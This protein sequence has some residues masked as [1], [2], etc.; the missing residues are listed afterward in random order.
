M[1]SPRQ[2][3]GQAD[4]TLS[5]RLADSRRVTDKLFGLVRPDALYERPI[6]ERHRLIFY[7]G[8]LEAFDWNLI[9]RHAFQLEPLHAEF[10]NLFAF[11]IDPVDG[12]LPSDVPADWPREGEVRAY[13]TNVRSALDPLLNQGDSTL[14]HVAIEHRLMHAETLAYLLHQLPL[15]KKL[16]PEEPISAAILSA[17]VVSRTAAIPKET[18]TLGQLRSSCQFGWDNEFEEHRVPVAGFR[19]D[20]YPVTNSQFLEFWRSGGY[21]DR[22]FWCDEDWTWKTASGLTHPHF[23]LRRRD[24]WRIRTMFNEIPLPLDW[25][26]YVSHAESSAYARWAGKKIPTEAQWHRMAYGTS[27]GEERAYPWGAVAPSPVH[28][29]FDFVSW[30]PAPVNS[31]PRVTAHLELP[32]CLETDG[33]GPPRHFS[34]SPGSGHLSFTWAIP[35][36]SL[37]ENTLS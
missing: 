25:P 21:D 22:S 1:A 11:G 28:G 34:L 13:C 2:I 33:N 17:P 6:P 37:T 29:N 18:A 9:G 26:V 7:L 19:A 24:E 8:H 35:R 23:W 10:D 30:D 14:L 27:E 12:G 31:H 3:V 16:L 36:I 5:T 15:E 20:V 4:S 32:I